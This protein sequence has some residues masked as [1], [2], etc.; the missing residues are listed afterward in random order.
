[1]ETDKGYIKLDKTYLN[2]PHVVFEAS[3]E[4]KDAVLAHT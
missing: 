2:P 4:H 3:K 1:M